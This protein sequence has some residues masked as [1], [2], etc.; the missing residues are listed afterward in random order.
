[1]IYKNLYLIVITLVFLSSCAITEID[2]PKV[3]ATFYTDIWAN[4][5]ED[6]SRKQRDDNSFYLYNERT[7]EGVFYT[8]NPNLKGKF[9]GALLVKN[10]KIVKILT[11]SEYKKYIADR[12]A[13]I[14]DQRRKDQL[15]KDQ[16]KQIALEK[17]RLEKER[18]DDNRYG[19]TGVGLFVDS[20]D[21]DCLLIRNFYCEVQ[22]IDLV[23]SASVRNNLSKN[24]SDVEIK[25]R[26]FAQSGTELRGLL[27]KRSETIFQTWRPGEIRFF[28]FN[29]S[30]TDQRYK[31]SCE[32]VG[33]R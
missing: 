27:S 29:I 33:W 16:Q 9:D 3:G 24:I 15:I 10:E 8:P 4:I 22:G 30:D 14:D 19:K 5:Q 7:S 13:A 26:H 6:G 20:L 31:T 2:S 17:E 18:Q 25:C 1:M 23:V 12:Q 28:K 32:I 11:P 21:R